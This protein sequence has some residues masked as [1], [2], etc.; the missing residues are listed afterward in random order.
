MNLT[1]E[2][3]ELTAWVL[4]ELPE[5]KHREVEAIISSRPD[6]QA[7]VEQL[8]ALTN[9]IGLA[10]ETEPVWKLSEERRRC[11]L[12]N[13]RPLIKAGPWSRIRSRLEV[14]PGW[15]HGTGWI[16]GLSTAAAVALVCLHVSNEPPRAL[17]EASRSL[18]RRKS[19]GETET[20]SRRLQP[21]AETP[22]AK[23]ET[24]NMP[25]LRTSKAT[26][27]PV[28]LK[29]ETSGAA[30][31]FGE[32]T[33]E[34][35]VSAP[36]PSSSTPV[37]AELEYAPP[38]A[39]IRFAYRAPEQL[40][41]SLN[42]Q[43]SSL[44]PSTILK[45]VND[46]SYQIVRSRIMEGLRPLPE[47]VRLEELV[48]YFRYN[49]LEDH[50][51]GGTNAYRAQLELATCPWN[52][53]HALLRV[54]IQAGNSSIEGSGNWRLLAAMDRTTLGST[55]F[56]P[57]GF[58]RTTSPGL[59]TNRDQSP[60]SGVLQEQKPMTEK[61]SSFQLST[62]SV[63][64]AVGTRTNSSS[65][66]AKADAE[67]L[68]LEERASVEKNVIAKLIWNTTPYGQWRTL[69]RLDSLDSAPEPLMSLK[70]VAP[71]DPGDAEQR[72]PLRPGNQYIALFEL[73]PLPFAFGDVGGFGGRLEA[74]GEVVKL[75]VLA[76]PDPRAE[77]TVLATAEIAN[78][79][80]P[81]AEASADFKFSVSVAAFGLLLRDAEEHDG[82]TWD[83]VLEMA[84]SG[85]AADQDGT[86]T[87]WVDLVNRARMMDIR[88]AKHLEK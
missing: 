88:P 7:E 55:E 21:K 62:A 23:S 26:F 3:P 25:H 66:D 19:I 9:T 50:S 6:L 70:S 79:P 17:Q 20:V 45:R 58:G 14:G 68:A 82:L 24:E 76:A 36:S 49:N 83:L 13:Q 86:R 35:F 63:S 30:K 75:Q 10:L 73:S 27:P 87:E 32:S 44:S 29:A 31:V 60:G 46:S 12:R 57:L 77:G 42:Y 74:P 48:N 61:W 40:S 11:I 28:A 18:A 47:F 22:L 39:G 37:L 41:P 34:P 72:A 65:T 4:G 38:S 85:I 2:S 52:T 78:T 15:F 53:R 1:P 43:D 59:D 33:D 84:R 69:G 54:A 67:I 81:F 5:T 8:R 64:P 56:F 71:A 80:K 16:I 51:Q